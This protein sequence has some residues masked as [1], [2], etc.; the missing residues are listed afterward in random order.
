MHRQDAYRF[1]VQLFFFH[2]GSNPRQ[3]VPKGHD[4]KI[5]YVAYTYVYVYVY[6]SI[7]HVCLSKGTICRCTMSPLLYVCMSPLLVCVHILTLVHA[8]EERCTYMGEHLLDEGSRVL[9]ARAALTL[10]EEFDQH[11]VGNSVTLP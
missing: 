5:H 6:V 4:L 2:G 10:H 3:S 7:L 9:V 1:E 11:L 8:R